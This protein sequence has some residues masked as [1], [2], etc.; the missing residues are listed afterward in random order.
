MAANRMPSI[1]KAR[2]SLEVS[3]PSAGATNFLGSDSKQR[4]AVDK[5][6]VNAMQT[7]RNV[8]VFQF[9][10]QNVETHHHRPRAVVWVRERQ[11]DAAEQ[12]ARQHLET[13]GWSV[14]R[15]KISLAPTAA[16]IRKLEPSARQA[17]RAALTSGICAVIHWGRA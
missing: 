14:E 10:I 2:A 13:L 4:A 5:R 15:P 16:E 6:H 12:Q 17:Y 3:M 8:R 9:N 7:Q 1:R 11:L